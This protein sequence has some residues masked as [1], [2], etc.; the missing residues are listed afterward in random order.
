MLEIPHGKNRIVKFAN[1]LI[2]ECRTSSAQRAAQ[3]RKINSMVETGRQDGVR[4]KI[5]LMRNLLERY[6][7]HLFSPTDL[8]FTI[9]FENDY[10]RNILDRGAVVGRILTRDWERNNTDMVFGQGVQDGA[11]YGSVIL[12]QWVQNEG[13]E[14]VPVYHKRIVM[15]WAFGVYREDENDIYKQSVLCETVVLTLPEVW[16]RIY[17]LPEA[18]KLMARVKANAQK[19]TGD[20]TAASFFH[21]VLSTSQINTSATSATA[22]IPGGIVQLNSDPNYAIMG[23]EIAVDLVKMHELWVQGENDYVTIQL[24]EPDILVC[25]LYKHDNLLIPGKINTG[26]HPYTLIQPNPMT[27]YFFGQSALADVFEPQ[28]MLSTW[29]DDISRLFGLQID[30]ILAFPGEDGMTDERYDQFRAAGYVGLTGGATVTDLTPKFPPEA[31]PMLK[32]IMETINIVMGFPPIMQGQGEQGVRAG[33]HAN[34]LLKTASPRLRDGSL[35]IERQ[36]AAAADLRLSLMEAKDGRNYWTKGDSLETVEKSQFLLSD[37]PEDRRVSVD[38]HSS[39]PI[40]ADD[41]AQLVSFGVTRGFI[42]GHRAIDMLPFPNKE[43]LQAD[44]REKEKNDA[45]FMQ[46]IMKEHPE[47]GEKLA[48]KKLAGGRR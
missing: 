17:H 36:C 8:R 15:P 12:K 11:K 32:L 14:Q 31:M 26:L 34:T 1:D 46:K 10:P 25:P 4:S 30:K 37:L 6:A 45:E 35:L 2:E 40:F 5:N 7:S 44:L 28:T 47:I 38:S 9:D 18:D 33:S 41:H 43:I 20:D 13:P 21:Q 39:S 3:C 16:R 29:A 27:G 22:P 19:G 42:N 24:I 48:L 23:P